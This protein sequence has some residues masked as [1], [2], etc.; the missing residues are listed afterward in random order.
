MVPPFAGILF[1]DPEDA[2]QLLEALCSATQRTWNAD[3][4]RAH[5]V[6]HAWDKI[7]DRISLEFRRAIGDYER[8]NLHAPSMNCTTS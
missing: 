7:A 2:E 4:I 1:D 8:Q 6:A 5:A 3:R